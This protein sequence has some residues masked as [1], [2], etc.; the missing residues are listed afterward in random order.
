M[1]SSTLDPDLLSGW[2]VRPGD[3]QW[4]ASV[5]HEVAPRVAVELSYLRRWLVNFSVI[6]NLS[7]GPDDHDEFGIVAPADSRLPGGGGYTIPGFY[8]VNSTAAA[9]LTDNFETLASNIAE[10]KQLANAISMNVTARPRGGLV[11]QGGFNSTRTDEDSCELRA[12][13]P[14]IAAT[15]PWCDT[16]SGW[17]TRFTAVGTYTIPRIDVLIA[18][19]MR[20]DKGQEL[21]AN[22]VAPNS[23][24]V[25]LDRPFAGIAG[26][27]IT[28]NLI[29]PGT[30][31]GD[32]IN[33]I[34]LR[35]AKNVRLGRVR[36]NI[37]VDVY[38]IANSASVL[39]YN[40]AFS[41]STTP[42]TAW[43]RPNSVL[44]SRFAKIS[45]QIDF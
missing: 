37:G 38:N 35:V 25:G 31:Y 40:Q 2:G 20:S 23:A 14:E 42:A 45:A 13:V 43:L 7:R 18:G 32:R 4:G 28:V 30:L 24:T 1:F 26:Q 22:W 21:A 29:E 27:T 12:L 16:S 36:T 5:Q 15:N 33:Q 34:D 11:V 9:R 19:T 3:W 39:T 17:L 44:Q 10:R 8:N 41:A 6:D